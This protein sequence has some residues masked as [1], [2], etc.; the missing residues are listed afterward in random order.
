MGNI[1]ANIIVLPDG[2]DVNQIEGF[3]YGHEF[4]TESE[5]HTNV[6]RT[7]NG[8]SILY[9]DKVFVNIDTQLLGDSVISIFTDS[10]P[11][12]L[13]DLRLHYFY[14]NM[15]DEVCGTAVLNLDEYFSE[16]L[17]DNVDYESSDSVEKL[18]DYLYDAQED[19]EDEDDD[20]Y[21]DE[22][23]EDEYE[24]YTF[25]PFE[26][27]DD[28][29]PSTPTPSSSRK[30]TKYNFRRSRLIQSP[31]AKKSFKRHNILVSSN[32]SDIKYDRKTLNNILKY[33]L[34]HPDDPKWVDDYRKEL[35]DRIMS[36]L[37]VT[38]KESKQL[39]KSYKKSRNKKYDKARYREKK[40]TMGVLEKILLT[41][42]RDPFYDP[43]K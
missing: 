3:E 12:I 21:D 31:G 15:F 7:S 36:V 27:Y 28:W 29:F 38:K 35:L 25:N 42:D 8:Y 1:T 40:I 30:N 14:F 24:P 19:D 43:N 34:Y 2:I 13:I 20:D 33:W 11:N 23:D 10:I 39:A 17:R 9:R 6:N 4:S 32:K 22:D 26:Q 18:A 16:S 41:R 5:I 37:V